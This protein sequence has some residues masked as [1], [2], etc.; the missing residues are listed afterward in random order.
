MGIHL[1]ARS[2]PDRFPWARGVLLLPILWWTV[3]LGAQFSYWCFLDNVNLAFHEAGHLVFSFA[4]KTVHYLGGT[5]GQL[6]VPA[7][8]AAYFLVRERKPFAAAVCVWWVGQNLINISVYMADARLLA[9]PLVGGGDHDWNELFYRFGL[10]T[11]PAVE[12]I[13]TGTHVLGT[14]IMVAG[15]A[16]AAYFALP[17]GARERVRDELTSR[18]PWLES[19]LE[20]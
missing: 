18:L 5:L 20:S 4:G 8:L 13:S 19:I 12:N 14:V 16:W 2:A 17:A 9:I 15:L 1:A 11:E 3:S 6:L 7:G 10:L